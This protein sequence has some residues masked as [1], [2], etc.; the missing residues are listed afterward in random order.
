MVVQTVKGGLWCIQGSSIQEKLS[1]FLFMCQI[2]S[3]C[4]TG[5]G[6]SELLMG[7][8]LREWGSVVFHLVSN[9]LFYDVICF[10]SEYLK[11]CLVV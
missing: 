7:L 5:V 1:K 2:T 10:V 8:R 6:R 11:S 4:T 3:D 9:A